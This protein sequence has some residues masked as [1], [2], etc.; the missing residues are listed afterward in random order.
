MGG[1]VLGKNRVLLTL[2]KNPELRA[3]C[4]PEALC[5]PVNRDAG[6][7][8]FVNTWLLY[9]GCTEQSQKAES[10]E[11]DLYQRAVI[12]CAFMISDR[13]PALGPGLGSLVC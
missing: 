6:F 1:G 12:K 7:R 13:N 5:T 11:F 9:G 8:M 3:R 4:N 10:A 2:V